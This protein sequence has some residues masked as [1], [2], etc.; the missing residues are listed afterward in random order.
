MAANRRTLLAITSEWMSRYPR[1][2]VALGSQAQSLEL[3]GY[4]AAPGPGGRSALDLVREMRRA[5]TGDDRQNPS[6]AAWEV[7]LLLKARRFSS[8]H[9][10]AESALA[11]PAASPA[12]R[13]SQAA[14]AALIGQAHTAA[15]RLAQYPERYFGTPEGQVVEAPPAL[16]SEAARLLA[17]ASFGAPAESL[18]II[19]ARIEALSA[20]GVDSTWQRT[21]RDAVLFQPRLLAFPVLAPPAGN[22]LPIVRIE[23][24]LARN[25]PAAARREFALLDVQRQAQLPGG[26][27]PDH[28]LLEARLLV[29]LGDSAA[30]RARLRPLVEDPEALGVEV[31]DVVPQ[32]AAIGRAIELLKQVGVGQEYRVLDTVL[33]ALW[34]PA[35]LRAPPR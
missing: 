18:R 23:Q 19:A 35:S 8:A 34:R 31:L 24:A 11:W 17:Y 14:L 2:P 7:R 20:R 10:V 22:A 33:S 28:V 3:A 32:A 21:L 4:A 1:S 15:A 5:Q 25:D 9:L 6:L 12:A 27:V 29:L 26:L 30:A 13:A 16:A